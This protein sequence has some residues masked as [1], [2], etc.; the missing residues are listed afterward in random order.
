MIAGLGNWVTLIMRIVGNCV[1]TDTCI[2]GL[3]DVLG[4]DI[5]IK[6]LEAGDDQ[7]GCP[8]G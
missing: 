6:R 5:E 3:R 2:R 1:T 7:G 8:G 4:E